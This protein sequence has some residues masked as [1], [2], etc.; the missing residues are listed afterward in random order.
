VFLCEFTEKFG[1]WIGAS[2]L[3]K[4]CLKRDFRVQV[5]RRIQPYLL[6]ASELHLLLIYGNS[7]R[8]S[9]ELIIVVFTVHLHPVPHR[10]P[11]SVD[12]EPG[13]QVATLCQ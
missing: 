7:I 10:L 12:T 3:R 13:K 11:G 6:A 1:G 5:N 2:M 8:L 9:N 4:S